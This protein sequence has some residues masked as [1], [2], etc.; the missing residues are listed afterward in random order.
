MDRRKSVDLAQFAASSSVRLLLSLLSFTLSP[1]KWLRCSQPII[2]SKTN[3][4]IY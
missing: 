1:V 3:L 4:Q 2:I